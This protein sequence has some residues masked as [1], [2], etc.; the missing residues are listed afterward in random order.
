MGVS[1]VFKW[2][3]GPLF[4]FCLGLLTGVYFAFITGSYYLVTINKNSGV[5]YGMDLFGGMVFSFLF[6][7]FLIPL[8]EISGVLIL[9]AG[10]MV[11]QVVLQ[12][13]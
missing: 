12:K 4:V 1:D 3:L 6:S 2:V 7:V 13:E 10:M 8:L 11:V 5:T 9:L